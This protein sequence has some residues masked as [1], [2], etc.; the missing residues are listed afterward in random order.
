MP[1][2]SRHSAA[3]AALDPYSPQTVLE[4]G[5][6]HGVAVRLLLARPGIIGVTALDRSPKMIAAVAASAPEAL[7]AGRLVLRAEPLEEADFGSERFDAI[8]AINVDF[9]LR[10]GERWPGLLKSLLQ[11]GG[12][13]VLAFEPPPG[14]DKGDAFAGLSRQR[15]A[16]AGLVVSVEKAAGNVTVILAR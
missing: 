10:L 3:V 8:M 12:I 11:P 1:I 15:L 7:A 2:A 16:A 5:C 6:G 9:N 13:I 4:V 14:S